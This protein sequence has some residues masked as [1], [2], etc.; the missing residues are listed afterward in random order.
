MN[1]LRVSIR[2]LL[3]SPG[4]AAVT[5]LTLAIAIGANT[6]MFSILYAVVLEPLPFRDPDRVVRVW[7][8]DEHNASFRES[9]SYPDLKDWKQQQRV[10]AGMAGLSNKM[11]NLT[12]A[13]ADPERVAAT[14]V[15]HDYFAMLGV[16]PLA[17]RAFVANDDR[18]GA[19]PVAILTDTLWRRR[20]GGSPIVGQTITL[21]G[22]RY[23][24][25]G[26]MPRKASLAR[27]G[28]DVFLPLTTALAPFTDVRGMHQ[29]SVVARL[30][31]GVTKQQ[32]AG[33][34]AVISKRL[35]LAH[36][37]D[38]KGRGSS[39]EGVLDAMVRDARPRLFVLS[40]AVLAVLLIACLNV[41]GLMLARADSRSRELAIRASLG[42][43]RS[44]I[45]RQLLTESVALASVGGVLGVLLAWWATKTLLA[46]APALPRAESI[47]VNLPVLLFALAASMVSA[48]LFGVV[49]AI[50]TS[51]VQPAQA[52]G[53]S[54]GVARGTRTAGRGV[55][56]VAEVALAVVLVIGA[57]LL[58]KSFM[59]LT[60]VDV[61]LQTGNI[62]T[63]AI[64]L[65]E[66][67][68]PIPSR[69]QYPKWPEVTNFYDRLLEQVTALPSV[70]HA[71]IAMNHPLDAGWTS[72]VTVAGQ[73]ETDGPKD[74]VR[75]RAVTP[76][77]FETLGI[78]VQRGR[79]IHRD[80]RGD[81]PAVVVINDALARKYFRDADPVGKQLVMWGTPRT[82]VGI[83]KGERF[84][85][86]QA[87]LEPAMYP[88]LAQ[89]PMGGVTL[90]V[91]AG[92]NMAQVMA[93]VRGALRTL[94][95]DIAPFDVEL[96][97]DTLQ[98][99]I[100]TPRFQ[101][102]LITSFGAIALLLAAIGLYALIAYQVQQRTNEIGIR[103][104]LGATTREIGTLILGRA[105]TLALTGIAIGL[106]G[107]VA[108]GR[109]LQAMIFEI[110][111]RDPAVYAI[112]PILLA[113]IALVA[114]WIPMRR[115]MRLDPA[116]ALHVE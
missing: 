98:R 11:L 80:D 15:S 71:A 61:G 99:T 91:R 46:F 9:A 116:T 23:E 8:T 29:V 3:K 89:L 48:I 81:A 82:I 63:F 47:G 20:F 88:P 54:R 97:D 102:V 60:A 107:A 18:D 57:G 27:V 36:P 52:L 111:P 42:A 68:Y 6:A 5:I 19:E 38:N 113:A 114:T 67:K 40:G 104:A 13:N 10:F 78:A 94:D 43:T 22:T 108:A 103:L 90:I 112:V 7:Q 96:L 92:G 72:Q 62:A 85:G 32:A 110:S 21:D 25:V 55:L 4:F 53:S 73:P 16:A 31:D 69:E 12:G 79:T 56:V 105:A 100:A 64:Q 76:G 45:V 65:P 115:A 41:A 35:E 1:D 2:S 58:L 106:L 87:E 49:P 44:R 70:N 74:E 14:G 93:G 101:A 30:R 83:V 17:G 84:G 51:A 26:V 24:V 50:R 28:T 77:Y 75:I 86:P 34:M 95:G 39:V 59:R 37:D 109:F 66:A 33:A